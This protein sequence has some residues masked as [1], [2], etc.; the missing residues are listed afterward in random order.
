MGAKHIGF[1]MDGNGRW[2]VAHGMPRQEGYAHGLVALYK[3]AKKCSE[4]G[5]EAVSVYALS[6]ENLNRPQGELDSI[7]KVVE[8]FNLTYDGEYKI[9]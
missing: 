6:T 8:K 1:I 2:A 7:F 9:S 5:V 3:V 4:R